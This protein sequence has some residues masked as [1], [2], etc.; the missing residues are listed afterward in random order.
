MAGIFI[1]YRRSD[2]AAMC[3]RIY[4][5][6]VQQFGK[7]AIFKDIDNIPLG[8]NF[9]D[10]IR[11]ILA[12]SA[13]ALVVIG[14]TWLD[15]TDAQGQRRLDDPADF[16]RLEIEEA[17]A[18]NIPVIPL[19]VDGAPMPSVERLPE[20]LRGLLMQNGWEVHY[21]P[22]FETDLRH[23]TAGLERL[24]VAS[25]QARLAQ[26]ARQ[27][28]AARQAAL[29]A[30][31]PTSYPPGYTVAPST[32]YPGYGVAVSNTQPGVVY[33]GP[34]APKSPIPRWRVPAYGAVFGV[35]AAVFTSLAAVIHLSATKGSAEDAI[36]NEA[37]VVVLFGIGVIPAFLVT[38]RYSRYWA[39]VQAGVLAGLLTWLG[40]A[41]GA[42][43]FA[44]QS[45]LPNDVPAASETAGSVIALIIIATLF[46]AALAF[47][48]GVL[49]GLLALLW[50]AIW[51]VVRSVFPPHKA[52]DA[53]AS[54]AL[55]TVAAETRTDTPST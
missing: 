5:A 11:G 16:V 14:R 47:V 19:R 22:Y 23:V 17:L 29:R 54:D 13:V 6:L 43:M 33:V 44:P 37:A 4:A 51:R 28:E 36:L 52:A 15:V 46:G 8:V 30:S 39:G 50:A 1:S 21:D 31:A 26:Y 32:N 12:Q 48:A 38:L 35:A 7:D 10:Y 42:Q 27:Q 18:R 40:F 9:A 53:Q 20:S 55:A 34:T 24:G 25:L 49:G 2:S 41:L 45:L 3:D